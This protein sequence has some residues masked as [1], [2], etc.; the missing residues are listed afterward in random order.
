MSFF[1]R[2]VKKWKQTIAQLQ[3][4]PNDVFVIFPETPRFLVVSIDRV[5]IAKER[6][7]K[8]NLIRTDQKFSV[9]PTDKAAHVTAN[10]GLTGKSQRSKHRYIQR[11]RIP[12]TERVA[13][14]HR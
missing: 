14:P 13:G 2:S 4:F 10:E 6:R 3:I 12:G 5:M 9:R 8:A 1:E 7:E 11:Q